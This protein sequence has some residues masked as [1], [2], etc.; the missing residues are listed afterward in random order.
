[1]K[2]RSTTM[3]VLVLA[4]LM[5]L[6]SAPVNAQEAAPPVQQ[7][8]TEAV[9]RAAIEAFN[10]GDLDAGMALYAEDAA[11]AV[12]PPP[13]PTNNVWNGT[14]EIRTN[15]E[16][17]LGRNGQWRLYDFHEDGETAMFSVQ[18]E[19]DDFFKDLNLYPLDFTGVALVRDG[20]IV[21]EAWSMTKATQERIDKVLALEDNK[22]IVRRFYD[23]IWNEGDMAVADEIMA[24]DFID[25]FTGNDGV[26][27]LKDVVAMF[28]AA[29]P[30][31]HI[32]Y[33][34]MIAEGDLV[35]VTITTTGTYAG[36]APDFLG[37]P[38][39]AIGKELVIFSG[40]DYAQ[41]VDGQMVKGWGTHDELSALIE[42]G[43]EVVPPAE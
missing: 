10:A 24:T 8:E 31:L 43:Y 20:L 35:A 23:E 27:G 1:M 9:Y 22:A 13:P 21:S 36:G 39:S 16:M 14:D 42:L 34:D 18:F 33:E 19:S 12:V 6:A 17:L 25:G 11:K 37:I 3:A 29:Y 30:D 38:D 15:M 32:E 41:I 28:R 4:C 2:R 26:D 40:V 5:L 7:S